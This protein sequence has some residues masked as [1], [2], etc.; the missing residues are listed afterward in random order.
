MAEFYVELNPQSNGDHVV[1]FATC[2]HLPTQDTIRYLGSISNCGSALKKAGQTYKQV[3][4]CPEC[5]SAF[6]TA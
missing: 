1:H 5:A 3:N 2:N 6:Y 4:G